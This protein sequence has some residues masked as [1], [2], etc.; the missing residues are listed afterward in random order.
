MFESRSDFSPVYDQINEIR[1]ELKKIIVGQNKM[2][3]YL[4]IALLSEGHVLIEGF[5]GLAKTLTVKI[6]ARILNLNYN[7]IQFTPDLMPS[8]VIG[9]S[10][11]NFKTQEF[12]F[13]KGPVFANFILADEINRA[14][15]KTQ[16]AL[17]EVMEERQIS[18]EGLRF[19]MDR[20][21]F[22]I[23]TQ[24]PIDLEGTYRL[25]E[26][27]LDRF[28]FR[29]NISYPN[30][31]EE[32]QILNRFNTG[33]LEEKLDEI[34]QVIQKEELLNAMSFLDRVVVDD[35]ILQYIAQIVH[36]SRISPDVM[37]GGSP[38]AS[39]N[40]LRG[41]KAMAIMNGRD[42]VTPDDVIEV[43]QP[44]LAHRLILNPE[45]EME[46]GTEDLVVEEIIRSVEVPK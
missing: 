32:I 26:A 10:I 2:I 43:V 27:Q 3:D 23:A 20:P 21:F 46:G 35:K 30:L 45:K 19:E 38:R 31:E 9:T 12:Q 1:Q 28:M 18:A 8:D 13:Q 29:I 7:R 44:V 42:F 11:F 6:L 41:A 39:L 15:A 5:P 25:P 4:L 22:I 17:F 40:M 14:P 33:K 24:N 37:V 16:S 34:N 36:Q